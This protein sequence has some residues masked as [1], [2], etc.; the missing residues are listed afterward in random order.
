MS[1]KMSGVVNKKRERLE[2][3]EMERREMVVP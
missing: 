3:D 2:K 1:T